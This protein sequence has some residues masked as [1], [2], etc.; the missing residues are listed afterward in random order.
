[1]KKIGFPLA[2]SG[3]L[4]LIYGI[5]RFGHLYSVNQDILR[6]ALAGGFV[7]LSIA[8]TRSINVLVFDLAFEKRKGRQAPQVLRILLSIIVYVALFTIIFSS[9]LDISLSGLLT[10]SAVVSV[11][12]G[13]AMQ[14]TLGNFFAGIS[15]HIEQP[16]YIGDTIKLGDQIGRVEAVSWR[17]TAIRTNHNT[18]IIFPNSVVALQPLEVF[19]FA[20]LNR[21]ALAFSAAYSVPPQRVISLVEKT[22]RNMPHVAVEKPAKVRITEFAAS[23]I[24]YELLY[25]VK[26]YMKVPDLDSKIKESI[27]YTFFRSGIEIPFPTRHVL[28]EQQVSREEPQ[29]PDYGNVIDRV[30]LF[31]PLSSQEREILSKSLAAYLYAPGEV[32][33]QR[34][35]P[36][37]SMFVVH[38]GK[39]EVCVTV[40]PGECKRLEVLGPG[41]FFGEMALFTGEPRSADVIAI[42]E[43]VIFEIRKASLERL[44][45]ENSRLAEVL[46]LKVAERQAR[47]VAL[48]STGPEE[49]VPALQKSILRRIQHFFKLI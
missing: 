45:S 20:D 46:S 1:M 38:R 3:L 34:G 24:E 40:A 39:A 25:W 29:K 23:G 35:D 19:R 10:T 49:S 18:L 44:L 36:G 32:I 12:I 15:I 16:F 31:E 26:D 30:G 14:D 11:I 13:L 33:L 27:W 42:E 41:D 4:F 48:A 5:L 2:F 7:G 9:V 21:R 17:T 22:V 43:I 28:L 47:L 6:Y 8:L 37:D